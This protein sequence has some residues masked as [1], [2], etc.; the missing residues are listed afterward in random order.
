M[1]L[2]TGPP[3]SSSALRQVGINVLQAEGSLH[4]GR[5]PEAAEDPKWRCFEQGARGGP[6]LSSYFV[7]SPPGAHVLTGAPTLILSGPGNVRRLSRG[8]Q[9]PWL[10]G[11]CT[12][13]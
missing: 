5:S 6:G 4:T 2:V 3:A 1:T 10:P 13:S 12:P 11:H 9:G 8:G 7:P